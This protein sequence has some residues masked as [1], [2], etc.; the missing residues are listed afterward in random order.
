MKNAQTRKPTVKRILRGAAFFLLALTLA[1]SLLSCEGSIDKLRQELLSGVIAEA[2]ALV[3]DEWKPSA[4]TEVEGALAALQEALNAEKP[5]EEAILSAKDALEEAIS[6]L[7]KAADKTALQKEYDR[8][9]KLSRVGYTNASV[10]SFD[11]AL[12]DAENAPCER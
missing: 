6:T 12:E 11:A 3:P 1:L 9:S 8:L 10:K 4:Y 7:E 5:D 2:E